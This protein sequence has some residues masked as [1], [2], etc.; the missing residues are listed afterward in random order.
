MNI[1]GPSGA[2]AHEVPVTKNLPVLRA[3][4]LSSSDLSDLTKIV[5]ETS[6]LGQE[7]VNIVDMRFFLT[8]CVRLVSADRDSQLEW[9]GDE[10][11]QEHRW[12]AVLAEELGRA[13]SLLCFPSGT[14]TSSHVP[15]PDTSEWHSKPVLSRDSLQDPLKGISLVYSKIPEASSCS[16][17]LAL[18][19]VHSSAFP[20]RLKES[21]P[22]PVTIK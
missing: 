8:Y 19:S 4:D 11:T 12:V 1:L 3:R 16:C 13:R 17:S 6:S 22:D 18:P 10:V 2:H 5:P 15:G 21:F 9:D 7:A 20:N 14:P